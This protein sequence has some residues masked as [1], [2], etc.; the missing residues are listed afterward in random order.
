MILN[1]K[2]GGCEKKKTMMDVNQEMVIP[3]KNPFGEFFYRL[4]PP[5]A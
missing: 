2:E 3:I 5:S 1:E 4:H